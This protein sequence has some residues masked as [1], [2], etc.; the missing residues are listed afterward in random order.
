MSWMLI[1]VA[2]L[3]LGWTSVPF[4]NDAVTISVTNSH[5][6][7]SVK[8]RVGFTCLSFC[9]QSHLVA[10]HS[11]CYHLDVTS[12]SSHLGNGKRFSLES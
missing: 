4:K 10:A 5:V 8:W 7:L 12:L 2:G 9:S 1:Q 11:D 3:C 6:R